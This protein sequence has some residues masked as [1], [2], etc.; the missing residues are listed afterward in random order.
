MKKPVKKAIRW[1][2]TPQHWR[3]CLRSLRVRASVPAYRAKLDKIEQ[4]QRMYAQALAHGEAVAPPAV[5][6]LCDDAAVAAW[7]GRPASALFWPPVDADNIVGQESAARYCIDTWRRHAL[8]RERFP[9]AFT[10]Q[11]EAFAE[12]LCAQGPS[13]RAVPQPTAQL[14]RTVLQGGFADRARQYFLASCPLRAAAPEALTPAGRA[15]ALRWFLRHGLNHSRLTLEEVWWLFLQ[16]LQD[17]RRELVLAY[18]FTPAWQRAHPAALTAFGWAAFASWFAQQYGAAPADWLCACPTLTDGSSTADEQIRTAYGACDAWRQRH[19]QAL[20][21]VADARALLT[22][23]ASPQGPLTGAL[24]AQVD[25]LDLDTV[26]QQLAQPAINVIGHFCY[27]SGLRVSAQSLVQALNA[28]GVQTQL[29]DMRTD[30]MDEPHHAD[31]QGIE[32]HDITLIHVQPQP[33]FDR[34]YQLA[35][36]AE[37]QP[38][39]YRIA[40]WYWELDEIPAAWLEQAQCVD[41]VWTATE[42][43][44]RAL[45]ARLSLPVYTLFPSVKL[46]PFEPRAKHDFGLRDDQFTFLFAFHMMSVMER[47]NPLGLIRAFKQAFPS[48][49]AAQLVLK[50]AF[51]NR[52]P[53][54]LKQLRAAAAGANIR[55]IDAL[56][57][58]AE[59]LA[60]INCCDAYVSLHRSEGLGLTMAEAMLLGK[61]VIATDYSGNLEFMNSDNSLLVPC[62]LITI[63]H[64]VQPYDYDAK[65]RW[66]EPSVEHAAQFMRQL[67]NN[68]ARARALGAK[69]CASVRRTTSPETAGARMRERIG[70]IRAA[71]LMGHRTQT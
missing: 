4:T 25:A 22:W 32:C 65:L 7:V 21:T 8:L 48:Q 19:P 45:R 5:I 17:P 60:L 46:A 27:P 13:A 41:E 58:P 15:L 40:Y 47:K 38:R 39:T 56:Y 62:Q 42:F 36:L 43:V 49:E 67:Y 16:A 55:I 14:I 20:S 52:H 37:R 66:A 26:A 71:Q 33:L 51:G 30:A 63:G 29:R 59:M 3:Q 69:A 6:D 10:Q 61:P 12:F 11:R 9:L 54:L 64:A 34:V 53:T 44:A 31:F 50:I 70:K 1:L 23:L 28:A 57:N 35:D 2:L 18:R 24:R 68:P